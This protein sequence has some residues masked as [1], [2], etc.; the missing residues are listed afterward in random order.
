MATRI[1]VRKPAGEMLSLIGD[2]LKMKV[3]DVSES[4]CSESEKKKVLRTIFAETNPN[5]RQR[6]A[7]N[8]GLGGS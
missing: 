4:T 8:D 1:P 7:T 5:L 6:G 3:W 2:D